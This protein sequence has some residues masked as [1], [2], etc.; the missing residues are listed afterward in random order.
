VNVIVVLENPD[1]PD[2]V[3]HAAASDPDV[4]SA[5]G[6]VTIC[7]LDTAEMVRSAWQPSDPGQRWWP[8]EPRSR[9]C[10]RCDHTLRTA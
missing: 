3:V 4:P 9:A 6:P 1:S 2:P 8:P 10:P 5:P 7:G